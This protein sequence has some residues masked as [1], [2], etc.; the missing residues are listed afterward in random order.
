MIGSWFKT[1]KYRPA[2]PNRFGSP[3][4]ARVH[5]PGSFHRYNLQHHPSG[6]AMLTPHTV[7]Y[8]LAADVIDKRQ[9]AL[10]AAIQRHPSASCANQCG[11]C[12][13][14]MPSR[15]TRLNPA[16]GERRN[17]RIAVAKFRCSK[18]LDLSTETIGY[19]TSTQPGC[20]DGNPA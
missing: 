19:T 15:S 6:I 16:A 14:R 2:F 9:R 8:G 3:E 13:S 18:G 10:T 4:G 1:T 20:Q 17:A 12:R 11:P 5:C 7:H